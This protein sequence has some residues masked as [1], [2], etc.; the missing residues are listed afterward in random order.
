MNKRVKILIAAAAV[1][2]VGAVILTVLS[3]RPS[4]STCVEIVQNN[5][6]IYSLD[7][8]KEKNRSF[9]VENEDGSWNEIRIEDGKI[10]IS[11]SDCPDKTCIKTGVLR[12][13]GVPIVC[14]PHRLV[15]RF[16]DKEQ[17]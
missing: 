13:E 17:S 8:A 1:I 11:D 7:L 16:A 9:R 4:E 6:V 15:I 14:L 5:K 3:L 2:F 10:S 12:W